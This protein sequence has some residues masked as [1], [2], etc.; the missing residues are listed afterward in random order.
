M[1]ARRRS[2]SFSFF[3]SCGDLDDYVLAALFLSSALPAA[4][5]CSLVLLLKKFRYIFVLPS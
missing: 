3:S 5:V 4:G 1:W 2:L